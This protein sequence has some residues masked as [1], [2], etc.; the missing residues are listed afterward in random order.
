MAG[1]LVGCAGE[2]EPG[3]PGPGSEASA[4]LGDSPTTKQVMSKLGKGPNA[5]TPVIGKELETDPPA[6]ETIGP[7]AAEYARLAVAMG[8]NE[9]R[10]GS[11]E[12]WTDLS[13]AFAESAQAL[14]K[15][16]QAK[17]RKAA[18]E[19][20][21][22][23]AGSCTQCHREHRQMGPGGGGPGGGPSGR[24]GPGGPGGPGGGLPKGAL[25]PGR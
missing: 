8:K 3:G 2:G 13:G 18:L 24:G 11:K 4:P 17:D 20:H 7:H 21:G 22:Q 5:L 23:L 12:S 19:A 9:P 10:K 16:A 6:W 14:N 1:F 15:A 25:P